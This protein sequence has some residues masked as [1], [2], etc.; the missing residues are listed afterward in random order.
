MLAE[1]VDE[2]DGG[3]AR[4]HRVEVHLL[5]APRIAGPAAA[6]LARWDDL[7]AA[8]GLGRAGP[9]ACLSESDHH[10]LAPVA[11]R[12]AIP[13]HGEGLPGPWRGAQVQV[14][15]AAPGWFR[16]VSQAGA[17]AVLFADDLAT[18]RVIGVKLGVTAPVHGDVELPDG[19]VLTDAGTEDVGEEAGREVAVEAAAQ[20]AVDRADQRCP[21]QRGPGEHLLAVLDARAREDP[22]AARQRKLLAA[23]FREAE[24]HQCVDERKQVI[25]F[26]AQAGGQV[27]QVGR[28][29]IPA[30]Q[31]LG[32]A[33]Q[34]VNGGLRQ[35][36]IAERAGVR[37]ARPGR[38]RGGN[39]HP[40]G[41]HPVDLVDERLEIRSASAPRP[42]ERIAD[43]CPDT[44]GIR[45]QK[46]DPV[47][48]QHRFFDV[49]R[50]HDHGLGREPLALPEF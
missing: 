22:S 38:R 46:E 7:Q 39:A 36:G 41:H 17:D 2:H 16:Q 34:P 18:G 33:G 8:H 42:G 20:G 10:V 13:Q 30:E 50:D 44:A 23:E 26:K 40:L 11:Q 21:V 12:P 6:D 31:D 32:Q 14:Q 24:Q 47:G 49:V 35:G 15:R 45:A 5:A 25:D 27:G 1:I 43:V 29:V 4:E 28:A 48:E 3:P 37:A 9:P 19:L